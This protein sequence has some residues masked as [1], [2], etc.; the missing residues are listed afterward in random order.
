[1]HCK[2]Q[3]TAIARLWRGFATPQGA[4]SEVLR[5]ARDMFSVAL[6][7]LFRA[8]VSQA[9]AAQLHVQTLP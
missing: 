9:K 6:D 7:L 5:A 8:L 3:T 4:Q 2:A 1:M